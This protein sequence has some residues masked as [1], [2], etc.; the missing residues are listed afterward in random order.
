MAQ[1]PDQRIADIVERERARLRNIVRRRVPQA[2]DVEDIVQDVFTELVEANRRL[3]PIDHV[4]GW[5]FRVARVAAAGR[6]TDLGEASGGRRTG[7][8]AGARPPLRR[9]N[10]P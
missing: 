10:S 7:I 8:T 9:R 3:M 4:T 1:D 2:E 5:L 6:I